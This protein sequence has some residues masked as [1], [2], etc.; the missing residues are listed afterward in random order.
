[1]QCFVLCICIHFAYLVLQTNKIKYKEEAQNVIE[2]IM[3]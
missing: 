1:M 3:A 2:F